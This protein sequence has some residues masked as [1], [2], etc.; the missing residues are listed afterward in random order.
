[1]IFTTIQPA[2][3]PV[4]QLPSPPVLNGRRPKVRVPGWLQKPGGDQISA[5]YPR[6]AQSS[7]LPGE[8][9]IRCIVYVDT[10]LRN[11]TLLSE[12]PIGFGFGSAAI[13]LSSVMR[14]SPGEIDGKPTSG[15][16]ATIPIN[17]ALPPV[18]GDDPDHP[19]LRRPGF[20]AAPTSEQ[21]KAAYPQKALT[22]GRT[23]IGDIRCIVEKRRLTH[24]RRKDVADPYGFNDAARSLAPLFELWDYAGVYAF[25]GFSVDVKILFEAKAS[26]DPGFEGDPVWLET[27]DDKT[28]AGAF[29]AA[30]TAKGH[31]AVTASL[32]CTIGDDGRPRDC[33]VLGV[34][35]EAM[36]VAHE[37]EGLAHLYRA[38]M[39]SLWNRPTAGV[40]VRVT[41][42]W[43][44]QEPSPDYVPR[45]KVPKVDGFSVG[46]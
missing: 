37:A 27:P 5:F 26:V 45:A 15:F 30:A 18:P 42:D 46:L 14:M 28:L 12:K 29:P 40:K 20:S 33:K 31:S 1:M 36:D 34:A 39:W 11:C 22:E 38:S 35:P 3:P 8:A 21:I 41:I 2:D 23:G 43:G 19:L 9:V 44:R 17:F 7:Q 13:S 25:E 10:R 4:L 6:S 32:V 16:P 24:C